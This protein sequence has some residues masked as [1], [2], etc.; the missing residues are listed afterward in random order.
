MAKDPAF[1]FYPC[2]YLGGTMGFTLEQ[3]GAYLLCLIYQFNS[4]QFS[5]EKARSI[6]G[7]VWDKISDK[8]SEKNG[9]FFNKRL[10]T[11]KEKRL[12]YSESRRSNRK[13][14]KIICESHDE[15]MED[16]N[17]DENR[18]RIK[19]VIKDENE[20]FNQFWKAYPKKVGKAAAEKSWKKIKAP[21]ET[22]KLF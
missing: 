14:M 18:N 13:H 8:F 2:D 6:I 12:S 4:G 20:L 11:E 15:H 7:N 3:H 5:E 21:V 16:E 10:E 22:L 17:E 9:L 19:D 1:L